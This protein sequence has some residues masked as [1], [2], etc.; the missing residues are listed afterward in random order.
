MPRSMGS[1]NLRVEPAEGDVVE[2]HKGMSTAGD[3]VVD[4]QVDQVDAE[5]LV[6]SEQG[7]DF[8]LSADAVGAGGEDGVLVVAEAVEAS[9]GADAFQDFRPVGE[10]GEG[11]DSFLEGF[12]SL[13]VYAGGLVGARGHF[14]PPS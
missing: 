4:V 9:E 3:D 10:G 14:S 12:D 6:V 8:H 5:G 1:D 7:G 2:E 13:K 11:A